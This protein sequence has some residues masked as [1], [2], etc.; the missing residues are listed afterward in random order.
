MTFEIVIF[1]VGMN[2]GVAIGSTGNYTSLSVCETERAAFEQRVLA[3]PANPSTLTF[4]FKTA[5]SR[6]T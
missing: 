2:S 6:R 1:A 4:G 5:C 3:T